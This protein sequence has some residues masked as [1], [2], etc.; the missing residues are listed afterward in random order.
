MSS[1]VFLRGGGGGG[2]QSSLPN[3]TRWFQ[4]G[5]EKCHQATPPAD[6]LTWREVE[7][8]WTDRRTDRV[9]RVKTGNQSVDDVRSMGQPPRGAESRRSKRGASAPLGVRRARSR[10]TG[11]AREAGGVPPHPPLDADWLPASG[12]AGRGVDACTRG[13]F[14]RHS[15]QEGTYSHRRTLHLKLAL[16][17]PKFQS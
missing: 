15:R 8:A 17:A 16:H 5:T 4:M 11:G 2:A 6:R 13:C 9:R 1:V 12:E 3:E 7:P 10:R 14:V